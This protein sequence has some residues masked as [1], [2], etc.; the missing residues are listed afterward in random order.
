MPDASK[1]TAP[2][3]MALSKKV[4]LVTGGTRGIGRAVSIAL[5][6]AGAVVVANYRADEKAAAA[7]DT[8]IESFGGEVE[9]VKAD[10]SNP[11]EVK[12][13][14]DQTV[15]V[16]GRLDVLVN[17]AAI[18]ADNHF[19]S[20]SYEAWQAGWKRTLDTN[21]MSAANLVYCAVPQMRKQG[22]GKIIN[23][24]S[25]SAYRGETEFLD[26]AAS[27]AALTNF[28]M[29]CA[30]TLGKDN[31]IT[32]TVAPGF[33]QTEM[34][35]DLLKRDGKDILAQIPLGK[36]ATPDDVANAVLFLASDLSNY[37]NG[38]T[39]DVNGGSYFH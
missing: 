28:S 7:L 1:E 30:R 37:L 22:G 23:I 12:R 25:R 21:L 15:E 19:D 29:C 27:K 4:A 3:V 18:Y 26:Y 31:I 33:T 8:E 2:N 11:D 38:A 24:S 32:T 36:V 13:L 14:I 20:G 35:E 5:A 16:F 39:I 17:N 10:V 34:A 6:K 9:L